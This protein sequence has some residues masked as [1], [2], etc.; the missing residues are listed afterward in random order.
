[1]R[2]RRRRPDHATGGA[3]RLA[4]VWAGLSLGV[5]FIATP[6]KFLAPSLS[7]PVALDVGRATFHLYNG[8][9][10]ALAGLAAILALAASD[11]RRVLLAFVAPLCLVL[12]QAFWLL[13]VLDQRVERLQ[14]GLALAPSSL[15]IVYIA[16]EAGKVLLLLSAALWLVLEA[17]EAAGRGSWPAGAA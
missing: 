9:E 1:M 13:P 7:L 11:R 2:R 8:L 4:L 16:A 6:A 3:A 5:S 10:F 14:A 15:H 12:V 17:D